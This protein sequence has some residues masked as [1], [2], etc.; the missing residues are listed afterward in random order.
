[1]ITMTGSSSTCG[2]A[3]LARP[4]ADVL[5]PRT[6]SGQEP[7]FAEAWHAEVLAIVNALVASYLFS[8]QEW[9][10]TF[11]ST[12]AKA[13]DRSATDDSATYYHCALGALETLIARQA[14]AISKAVPQRLEEWRRAYL[15]TP[16]G[17]PV[18]L[19]AGQ[20]LEG[21]TA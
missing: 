10:E 4:E 21:K 3:I 18:L 15:N 11:G 1:P 2:R 12:L 16:H 9:A 14:P 17:D 20:E 7:V 13:H 8:S 19:S 6:P 5:T